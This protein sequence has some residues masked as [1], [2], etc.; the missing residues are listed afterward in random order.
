MLCHTILY[1]V[2]DLLANVFLLANVKRNFLWFNEPH[3]CSV[4]FSRQKN[5]QQTIYL[6]FLP[7]FGCGCGL[8]DYIL[9]HGLFSS[10]IVSF[11]SRRKSKKLEEKLRFYY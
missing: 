3:L 7:Y 8:S 6:L 5:I 1:K 10:S 9:D 4:I 11:I 2:V